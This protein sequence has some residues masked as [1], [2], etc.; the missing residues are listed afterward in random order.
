MPNR[1]RRRCFRPRP[2]PPLTP[3]IELPTALVSAVLDL[4]ADE[5][6]AQ[7]VEMVGGVADRD[8]LADQA[9]EVL[10]ALIELVEDAVYAD[11]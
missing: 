4:A 11:D 7:R 8:D 5:D 6:R 9:D 2:Q 1:R 3:G 10:D